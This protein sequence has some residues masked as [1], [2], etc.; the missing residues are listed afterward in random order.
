MRS[1][2]LRSRAAALVV[3][4]C[5]VLLLSL[6]VVSL[7]VAMRMDR[8][9]S[10]YFSERSRAEFFAR[11]GVESAKGI[12]GGAIGAT[13]CS[14]ISMP[15][16]VLAWTNGQTWS[17]AVPYDLHSGALTNGA[18]PDLAARDLNRVVLSEDSRSLI[19]GGTAN[20]TPMKLG[21]IYVRKDGTRD[22][23][24]NPS[25]TDKTN[26]IIG[27]FAFWTDDE[28]SRVNLNTAWKRQVNIPANHPSQLPLQGISSD[29]SDDM[30][31]GIHDAAT[32]AGFSSPDEA[33]RISGVAPILS[34]NR[35]SV[36]HY[37]HSSDLNPFGQPKIYLTT[38]ISN[39]PPGF[40]N[41]HPDY[42]NYF[43]DIL[44]SDTNDPG[45][46]GNLDAA[47]YKAQLNKLRNLLATNWPCASG[48]YSNKYGGALNAI[49]IAADII[50]Y[51]R[52]AE[53]TNEMVGGIV[54]DARNLNFIRTSIPDDS[55]PVSG[56]A[57][58]NLI[59]DTVRRP[60]LCEIGVQVG[61][62]ITASNRYSYTG[63]VAFYLPPSYGISASSLVG[64]TLNWQFNYEA[65]PDTWLNK[66]LWN[67]PITAAMID[68]S[69]YPNFVIV[70]CMSTPAL[71]G[72]EATNRP[73]TLY[74]TAW[75]TLGGELLERPTLARYNLA[76]NTTPAQAAI[77]KNDMIRFPVDP[78]GIPLT[79]ISTVKVNDPRMNKYAPNWGFEGPAT[80]G[81]LPARVSV[82]STPRQDM[83]AGSISDAGLFQ[84]A[85]K[86]H[87]L[88]PHGIVGSVG[89]L[90]YI[91]SGGGPGINVP[92]RSLAL[93]PTPNSE[94]PPDWLLLDMFAAP[95]QPTNNSGNVFPDGQHVAGRINL[96][97]AALVPFTNTLAGTDLRLAPLKSLFLG[98][99]NL[100]GTP[101]DAAQR[102]GSMIFVNTYGNTNYHTSIGKLAEVAGIG[103]PNKRDE[104]LLRQIVDQ[105][106]VQGNVFR[107]YSVGQSLQQ[108]PSG[109]IVLQAEYTVCA[110]VERQPDGRF[111]TVYWKVVPL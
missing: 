13:D 63:K 62:Y 90:G 34:S 93:R 85:P 10:H 2:T 110:L 82:S 66:T 43:L 47:K 27:R 25:L 100:S 80:W 84:R 36:T 98:T 96:N 30:I 48:S 46:A 54:F 60:M 15:G 33:R 111:R 5:V 106:T 64:K 29:L 17:N 103:S 108:T 7:T 6:L 14:W 81:S 95:V 73:T 104:N 105:T 74:G 45:T 88:N 97:S 41:N 57:T 39:L 94:S 38:K 76:P 78:V 61:D 19:T 56:T 107:V 28:S 37:S 32:N 87:A 31:D 72:G 99:T 67:A 86:G 77:R 16:R 20:D 24:Q 8:Q 23:N 44:K 92:W 75:L 53:S 11:E 9:A 55:N 109:Q 79:N 4:L 51:V 58:N 40:T 102:V 83:D 59:M 42:T 49:Q 69:S 71:Y 18:T 91:R 26:P 12:L 3:T 101:D 22:D 35:F 52:S 65:A 68:G 70:T 21:W 89:E 50:G 1:H